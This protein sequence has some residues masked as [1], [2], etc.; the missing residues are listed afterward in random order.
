MS[1]SC[2]SFFV[3][4]PELA[5]PTP[6]ALKLGSWCGYRGWRIGPFQHQSILSPV[7]AVRECLR[8]FH[9]IPTGASGR[10]GDTFVPNALAALTFE[11]M[12][13]LAVGVYERS[14]KLQ[15]FMA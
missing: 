15:L 13:D 12:N 3:P 2:N 10:L 9:L 11:Y 4:W 1:L 7:V 14:D 6:H 5:I 8:P